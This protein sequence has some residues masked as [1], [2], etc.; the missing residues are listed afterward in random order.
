MSSSTPWKPAGRHGRGRR[1]R[2]HLLHA[3]R[4]RRPSTRPYAT[5][6]HTRHGPPTP[7]SPHRFHHRFTSDRSSRDAC[8]V[9]RRRPCTRPG[10][11]CCVYNIS[12][13]APPSTATATEQSI[14]HPPEIHPPPNPPPPGP[15]RPR[16]PASGRRRAEDKIGVM[17]RMRCFEMAPHPTPSVACSDP[18]SYPIH[19]ARGVEK[20]VKYHA[21]MRGCREITQ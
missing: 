19:T 10:P 18:L 17:R 9:H 5:S 7:S 20:A 3:T 16:C 13:G 2:S 4:T 15:A 1:G 12:R 11:P 21:C 8:H 6:Q 14:H